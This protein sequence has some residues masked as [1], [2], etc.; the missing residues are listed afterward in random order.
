MLSSNTLQVL[1]K[2]P[3]M[4]LRGI[5]GVLMALCNACGF[6][7]CGSDLL[8]SCGCDCPEPGC[9]WDV[10]E[11]CGEEYDMLEDHH[12]PPRCPECHSFVKLH[13]SLQNGYCLIYKCSKCKKEFHEDDLIHEE[14]E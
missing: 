10:C 14:D 1:E 7:C 6:Q 3:K 2:G 5:Y 8:G 4:S 13:K 11:W 9:H 12:C